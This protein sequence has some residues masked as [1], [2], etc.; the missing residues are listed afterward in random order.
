M[1]HQIVGCDPAAFFKPKYG[2]HMAFN[3]LRL[4][5]FSYYAGAAFFALGWLLSPCLSLFFLVAEFPTVCFLIALP[6]PI[7][8][9]ALLLLH[10]HVTSLNL[11]HL[12]SVY[13][14]PL[15]MFDLVCVVF[16]ANALTRA[17]QVDQSC[18]SSCISITWSHSLN[19]EISIA[20]EDSRCFCED[21]LRACPP[22]AREFQNS[23]SNTAQS[24]M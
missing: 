2:N 14:A 12:C 20:D 17:S 24:G 5:L 19:W 23:G 1:F 6:N 22:S 16:F 21:F 18:G 10:P 15:S 7:Q 9:I 4:S 3:L 8:Q 13:A 11:R